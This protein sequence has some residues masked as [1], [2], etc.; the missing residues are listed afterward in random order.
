[1]RLDGKT[2][3]ITGAASGI[4]NAAARLMASRGARVVL[5]GLEADLLATTV[6]D[7]TTAGGKAA[8]TVM[9]VT[10]ERQVA[11]G[12]DFAVDIFG[13]LDVAVANAGV[14]RHRTD[15]DLWQ[16]DEEELERTHDVN[17]RGV[18]RTAKH[19]LARMRT[20]ASGGSII[21]VSSITA[22]NGRTP[23]VAYMT[24][25]AAMLGLNRHIAVHYAAEGIRC[26]AVCPGALEQTPDFDQHPDP[27]GRRR[28]MEAAIPMGRLGTNDDIAPWIA[29]LAS[30]EAG[31]ANGGCIVVDGG[32]TVV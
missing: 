9:D 2:V 28:T 27:Q 12:M 22:L 32:L 7:I 31:Y 6:H 13:S 15:R 5:T 10:D 25:K 4:G 11:A 1:M 23:N 30:D 16:L 8:S 3:L 20:Q 14:Q 21:L 19:A 26:N 18:M 17:L 29:F 24:A